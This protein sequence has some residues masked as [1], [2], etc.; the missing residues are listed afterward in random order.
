MRKSSRPMYRLMT[1][2][3]AGRFVQYYASAKMRTFPDN[4]HAVCI[5]NTLFSRQLWAPVLQKMQSSN[6]TATG[7]RSFA[8]PSMCVGTISATLLWN[9]SHFTGRFWAHSEDAPFTVE[10]QQPSTGTAVI[11]S[12]CGVRYNWLYLLTYSR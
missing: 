9:I 12:G 6:R 2:F 4:R 8:L 5:R 3:H 7:Q 10:Q 1:P 11:Y